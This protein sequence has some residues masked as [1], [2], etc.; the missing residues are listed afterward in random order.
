MIG[1]AEL[2]KMRPTAVLIN[3][4]RGGIVDHDALLR[5]LKSKTIAGYAADVLAGEM[6]FGTDS[7]AHPLV[8]YAKTH[9]NVLLTPHIGGRTTEARRKTDVFIAEKLRIALTP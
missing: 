2:N 8:R 4:A 7:S 9:A 6:Q 1:A 3:A 5:A